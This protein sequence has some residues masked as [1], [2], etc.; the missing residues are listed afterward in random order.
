MKIFKGS[1]LLILTC[2][3][4]SCQKE[5][6]TIPISK[7]IDPIAESNFFNHKIQLDPIVRKVF[8]EIKN[9]NDKYHFITDFSKRNGYPIWEH[10]LI[11]TNTEKDTIVYIPLAFQNEKHVN[12]IIEARLNNEIKISSVT[13]NDYIKKQFTQGMHDNNANAFAGFFMRFDYKVFGQ[14]RFFINDNRLFKEDGSSNSGGRMF[15]LNYSNTDNLCTEI[16]EN[17]EWIVADPEHCTCGPGGCRDWMD[18]CSDCSNTFYTTHTYS[19]GDCGGGGG[20]TYN[21]GGG[22]WNPQPPG[23]GYSPSVGSSGGPWIPIPDT[24]EYQ[25]FYNYVLN[26]QQQ[27]FW[28]DPSK[29]DF[30]MPLINLLVNTNYSYETQSFIQWAI[31]Y[32]MSGTDITPTEFVNYFINTE[33]GSDGEYDAAYWDDPNLTFQQVPLPTFQAFIT[34]FPKIT[35][36]Q[37]IKY[38]PS[39]Q[40]YQ[41][42][43]GNMWTQHNAGNTYYQ[44]A[45]AVR[46]SRALN[47]CGSPI[48]N[49]ATNIDFGS[50]GKRYILSAKAFN[51]YMNKKYGAPTHRLT[52]AQINGNPNA[53][54][55]FLRG[56]NGIY[57]MVTN[58]GPFSGHV[59]LIIDGECLSGS[60]TGNIANVEFIEIWTLP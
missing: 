6:Q 10:A 16:T 21:T 26:A 51:K 56:K 35:V 43:G 20:S 5:M 1:L 29:A 8:D 25:D 59:D 41:M 54:K 58:G 53:I 55:N 7:N 28:N 48:N 4:F 36:P 42:V 12:S 11:A 38:M 31:N 47:Y 45:C 34:A 2:L 60:A 39:P 49:S 9:R 3:F 37:G 40:V 57:T 52:K 46:G 44:N 22:T 24:Q 30:V 17:I 19:I 27:S 33:N 23:G 50:D 13:R 15:K 18:G 14:T 32:L